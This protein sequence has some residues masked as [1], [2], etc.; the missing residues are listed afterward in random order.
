MVVQQDGAA[1]PDQLMRRY[2]PA[3]HHS[4]NWQEGNLDIGQ[5]VKTTSSALHEKVKTL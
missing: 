1:A 2:T 5:E 4:M 3:L